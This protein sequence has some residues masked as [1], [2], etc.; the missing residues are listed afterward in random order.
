MLQNHLQTREIGTV[1]CHK[2][3][4]LIHALLCSI[5][6]CF[7]SQAAAAVVG[8]SVVVADDDVKISSAC[9]S[10]VL[11]VCYKFKDTL[12]TFRL[13]VCG[14]NRLLRDRPFYQI[15]MIMIVSSK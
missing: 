14:T 4:H 7:D 3:C 2:E 11:R 13:E 10:S 12:M 5:V 8:V 9:L 15:S 1:N 6:V